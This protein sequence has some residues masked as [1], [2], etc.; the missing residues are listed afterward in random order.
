MSDK[1]PL[2]ESSPL[3]EIPEAP[4]APKQLNLQKRAS[5][6]PAGTPQS[7]LA[8]AIQQGLSIEHLEKLL[9]M[10]A[11]WE[12]KESRKEFFHA[13][14]N[15]QMGVPEI[16]KSK[17]VSYDHK[18]GQG[19]TEYF[20]AT[21]SDIAHSIREPLSRNGLSYRWE[22]DDQPEKITVTCII[23][24]ADGHEE[25]T[26]MVGQADNSG[27][28][29]LIQ[30]RASTVTYLQRYTLIGA[31]GISSADMDNDGQS[32]AKSKGQTAITEKQFT[33]TLAKIMKGE[34]TVEKTKEFFTLTEDQE[35]ALQ[36]AE[37]E[38]KNKKA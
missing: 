5:K 2:S 38:F 28:K 22:I 29:N 8:V 31:L 27:K 24:H 9:D 3:F 16:K 19:K 6:P 1:K 36:K 37:E 11:K 4:P 25:K 32:G 15:F 30:Q 33:A 17:K 13:L 7:L 12:A 21:L 14:S 18:D 10:Q 20:Y 26:T 34:A 23:T 35:K